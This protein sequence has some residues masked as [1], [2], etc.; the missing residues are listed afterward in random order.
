M[1]VAPPLTDH[2]GRDATPAAV[3][4]YLDEPARRSLNPAP[5]QIKAHDS[6]FVRFL[7]SIKHRS[8][9]GSHPARHCIV[10]LAAVLCLLA[11]VLGTCLPVAQASQATHPAASS[12]SSR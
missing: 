5:E 7:M 9:D 4:D 6:A 8:P 11:G 12:L 1:P 10:A 2:F 3:S